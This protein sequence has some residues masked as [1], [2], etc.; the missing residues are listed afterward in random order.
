MNT[1]VRKVDGGREEYC[2]ASV[3]LT[4]TELYAYDLALESLKM[5]QLAVA[6]K[7][8]NEKMEKAN[9]EEDE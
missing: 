5:E 2:R 4:S 3:R 6:E 8:F 9:N 1:K 7:L